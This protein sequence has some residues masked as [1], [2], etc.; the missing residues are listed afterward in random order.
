MTTILVTGRHGQVGWELARTLLPLGQVVAWGRAEADL[1]DTDALRA[2]VARLRPDVIVNAAA[3]T[4]VDRAE[5][6]PELAGRI[7][8]LA[9]GILAE[10]A[11]RTGALLVHY[12]T[13][14]VFDGTKEG[15]YEE[16]D[17]PAPLNAYGR[18]KLAGEQAIRAA[19]ADHL[20]LRTSWVYAARGANFL[21]TILRLAAER[22]EL[23]VVADQV[24]APTWAR[25]IAEAT[26][27]VVAC[28]LEE[29][30]R[31]A[32]ASGTY[33]LACAGETSWHGFAAA[34]LREAAALPGAPALR[35]RRVTPITTAEYPLPAPRPGNSRLATARLQV[36]FG[37][38]M[39]AWETGLR[40]CLEELYGS[41]A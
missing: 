40:L 14:Y 4:A 19:Q 20:I 32:F 34:L 39:P 21:R 38:T 29:R 12:S 31:G 24:G 23:R 3:Y 7:N 10:E 22:D 5:T 9:P 16:D 41:T 33:H 26:A 11:R 37:V 17:H 30:R 28:A 25:F 6:E 15:P 35:A 2:A 8:G 36:R 18:S 13:D 27:H 1:A